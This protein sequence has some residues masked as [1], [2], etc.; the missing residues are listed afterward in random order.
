MD[1]VSA[2]A[3]KLIRIYRRARLFYRAL[4]ENVVIEDDPDCR[5]RLPLFPGETMFEMVGALA[6]LLGAD[7]IDLL[8]R[9][10]RKSVSWEAE[11]GIVWLFRILVTLDSRW[12]RYLPDGSPGPPPDPDHLPTIRREDLRAIREATRMIGLRSRTPETGA[13]PTPAYPLRPRPR[14]R[15]TTPRLDLEDKALALQSKNP[16]WTLKQI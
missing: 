12:G 8:L 11:G 7:I 16:T 6:D 15:A 5:A 9:T 1:E 10:H 3:E 2:V 14:P 13:P 4:R